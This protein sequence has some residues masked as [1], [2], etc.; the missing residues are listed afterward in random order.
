MY[1]GYFALLMAALMAILTAA[2]EAPILGYDVFVPEWEVRAH[3]SGDALRLNGTAEEV[4]QQ[5]E[6]IN[7]DFKR[8]FNIDD[9]PEQEEDIKSP[10]ELQSRAVT[11]FPLDRVICDNFEPAKSSE[12]M[13]AVRYLNDIGGRPKNGGGPA[14]C[15]RVSC[16]YKVAVWWCNDGAQ[17]RELSGFSSITAGIYAIQTMCQQT[18][19]KFA[20]QAFH[21]DDW[22]VIV[23]WEDC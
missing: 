6:K 9:L 10:H 22:N 17:T 21:P 18:R 8:S 1:T 11:T 13:S 12:V 4:I 23:R 20:G 5:I 15:G 16:G 7:P 19:P 14:N 2:T 3:P